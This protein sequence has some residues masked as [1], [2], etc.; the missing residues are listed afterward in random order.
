MSFEQELSIMLHGNIDGKELK[1]KDG[2]K[3]LKKK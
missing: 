3:N 1:T 2:M